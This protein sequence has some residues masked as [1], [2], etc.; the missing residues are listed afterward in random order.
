MLS[1][2][3]QLKEALASGDAA[4]IAE[5]IGLCRLSG[6]EPSADVDGTLTPQQAMAA[7]RIF[8]ERLA[9]GKTE[10][11][12]LFRDFVAEVKEG[13]DG[14]DALLAPLELDLAAYAA[15]HA[16]FEAWC[17]ATRNL[18]LKAAE[19]KLCV[20]HREY[21]EILFH[22]R[23]FFFSV[24]EHQLL[25]NWRSALPEEV[26]LVWFLNPEFQEEAKAAVAVAVRYVA[27]VSLYQD[28]GKKGH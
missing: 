15:H 2:V 12:N 11:E 22:S 19:E 17:A 4:D 16:V 9:K 5:A 14:F 1:F 8:G 24:A 7:C 25:Q 6:T 26:Y 3:E 10:F 13:R 27:R 18:E 23:A 20:A 21:S 28:L